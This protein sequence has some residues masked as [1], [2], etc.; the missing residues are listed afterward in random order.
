MNNFLDKNKVVLGLSGGV[1]STAACL[2]L[3]EKSLSV[4]GLYFDVTGGNCEGR[5]AAGRIASEAGADFVYKDVSQS[6]SDIVIENFCDEYLHGRT[7]NPCVLC[8]PTVKFKTLIEEADRIGA[9]YIATGHYARIEYDE[10]TDTYYVAVA[11]N[12]KKDQSYMLYR[13][14][15]DVL[16]RLLLPLS[17]YESKDDIRSLVRE[18][19]IENADLKDSQEICFLPPDTDYVEYI[20]N[21]EDRALGNCAVSAAEDR[22]SGDRKAYV[23]ET[24][25]GL[26]K[27]N[28]VDKDGK[29]LGE[30]R[31]II[32]YTLGQRK[33]LGIALGKP[34]FVTRLDCEKNTVT[35]GES[36]DL[37]SKVV[38]ADDCFFSE[39]GN[40]VLPARLEGARLTAK[41][42]YSPRKAEAVVSQ[43]EDGRLRAEFFEAQ[44][45]ATPGQSMVL[46]DGDRVVGGGVIV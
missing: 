34:A 40:G 15:Q 8:N 43:M 38:Y 24:A 44:R 27:G 22:A 2:L 13:L 42:R 29:V 19:E 6:F 23:G 17:A 7:P 30:H 36:E 4:T 3:K 18:N 41:L 28:F 26:K 37:F 32:N 33:G 14:G 39:S 10:N 12:E 16:S 35:L 1:D 5:A 46:Y 20:K 45:A 9:Y 11:A 21:R 25:A 31:G